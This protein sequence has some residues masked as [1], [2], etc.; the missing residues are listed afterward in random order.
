MRAARHRQ[1]GDRR[2][3]AATSCAPRPRRSTC[4]RDLRAMLD[5]GDRACA[6]EVSSHALA[7]GRADGVA[8]RRGDLHEPDA[9]PSRLPRRHGGLLPGQAPALRARRRRA[10]GAQRRQCRRS[11]RRAARRRADGAVTFAI[12]GDAD[13]ARHGRRLR[14]WPA[15]RFTL[16]RARRASAGSRLPL[17]GRFNVANALGALARR[18]RAR[19]STLERLL[20]AL[21]RGVRV[22]GRFEPVDAGQPF[23]V[24]VDY[25]HTPDSLENVLAAA[26]ELDRRRPAT[27]AA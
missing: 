17:P 21:E 16:A 10:A 1:V 7:L 11:L 25:A 23:A 27:A 15:A 2:R 24:L 5:G 8:L 4:R 14:A 9:G 13:Y 12:D 3:R 22:P 26:R 18:A 19:A 6:M 20:G